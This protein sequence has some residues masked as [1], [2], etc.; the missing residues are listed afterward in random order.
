ME[1]LTL[2]QVENI[3]ND[4]L[5]DEQPVVIVGGQTF[6]PATILRKCDPIAYRVLINQWAD[7]NDIEID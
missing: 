6:S 2:E 5:N 1:T 7:S 4:M 3:V